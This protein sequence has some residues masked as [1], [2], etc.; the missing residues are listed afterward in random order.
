MA[1]LK[2]SNLTTWI[3]TIICH[4]YGDSFIGAQP[5]D[6]INDEVDI[7]AA[8]IANIQIFQLASRTNYLKLAVE[9]IQSQFA[10]TKVPNKILRLDNNAKFIA[11]IQNDLIETKLLTI[12]DNINY[13]T[14][15]N[16]ALEN[17]RTKS[18]NFTKAD[19]S[20]FSLIEEIDSVIVFKSKSNTTGALHTPIII[21][22][23]INSNVIIDPLVID[24]SEDIELNITL[25]DQEV[26]KFGNGVLPTGTEV[27]YGIEITNDARIGKAWKHVNGSAIGQDPDHRLVT[28][29]LIDLWTNKIDATFIPASL[30]GNETLLNEQGNGSILRFETS[31]NDAPYDSLKTTYIGIHKNPLTTGIDHG[32]KFDTI[33][34]NTGV[35][36]HLYATFLGTNYELYGTHN[37]NPSEYATLNSPNLTGVPTAPTAPVA[38][39]SGSLQVANL[40]YVFEAIKKADED[41]W[42]KYQ[43][44]IDYL[45]HNKHNMYN[46]T[47]CYVYHNI[48][49]A[50]TENRIIKGTNNPGFDMTT[51]ATAKWHNENMIKF[52]SGVAHDFKVRIPLGF[53]TIWLRVT[54]DR[55]NIYGVK[56]GTSTP[57]TPVFSQETSNTLARYSAGHRNLV[58]MTPDGGVL[59][60]ETYFHKWVP[61]PVDKSMNPTIVN[62]NGVDC[63]EV[64]IYSGKYNFNSYNIVP[65]DNWISGLAYSKNPFRHSNV[66]GYGIAFGINNSNQTPWHSEWNRDNLAYF[67]AGQIT[68]IR[69][70]VYDH[71]SV[72]E[73][74]SEHDFV[75]GRNDRLLYIVGHNDNWANGGHRSLSINGI[76]IE[77]FRTTYISP[78]EKHFN[79]NL[80]SNYMAARIPAHLITSSDGFVE[81]SIDLTHSSEPFYFREIGI[82]NF[83][84]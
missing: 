2:E 37:F 53:D 43:A 80:Y 4:L 16:L 77:R 5:A 36:A 9:D 54:N 41:K 30:Y 35:N 68:T 29:D 75:I 70:P 3:D 52:G 26:T 46:N 60:G 11:D 72:V 31:R 40:S 76:Q 57:N 67:R 49:T 27:Y 21:T 62:V 48:F 20:H 42:N 33:E 84:P 25:K 34:N 50:Y 69:I 65:G 7:S 13:S 61:I 56:H 23:D 73:D 22:N 81:M 39:N 51:Y 28:D 8:A 17:F 14:I 59:D 66:S 71:T 83:I 82:H 79:N 78:F 10:T 58:T 55:W 1:I 44:T 47:D 38:M 15:V 64:T 12:T 6:V 18:F 74:T 45:L 24:G 19:N 63:R 32:F